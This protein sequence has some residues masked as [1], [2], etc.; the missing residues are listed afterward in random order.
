MGGG[1]W[2]PWGT[3]ER[4]AAAQGIGGGRAADRG[5]FLGR[6]PSASGFLFARGPSGIERNLPAPR[7]V[8][9]DGEVRVL[10]E[11]GAGK[12]NGVVGDLASRD[13]SD[14]DRAYVQRTLHGDLG[15]FE[16]LVERHRDV[17]YRVAARIAGPD[18]AEDVSQDAFLR[19]FHR[20]GRFRGDAPF[21]AW[22]LQ[23]AHNAAVD[24]LSRR[25]PEP[26]EDPGE[27][28]DAERAVRRLPAERLESRER[29]ARLEVKLR[30][31]PAEQRAVLVLRDIEGLSYEEIATVTQAPLGTVKARL[32]RARRD[33]IEMLRHNTYDWELPE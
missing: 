23:I 12:A 5:L 10:R 13:M 14:V 33:L 18:D 28:E 25:R 15:A 24:H 30:G 2:E 31:L 32:F 29:I 21:R 4:P 27:H 16:E 9:D 7:P 22:L 20:L 19:A 8:L 17:V 26:V 11:R 6:L 3:G 1:G